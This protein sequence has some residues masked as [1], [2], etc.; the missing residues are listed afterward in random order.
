MRSID[1]QVAALRAKLAE[2]E[3][4]AARERSARRAVDEALQE[5]VRARDG[6]LDEVRGIAVRANRVGTQPGDVATELT[7]L[8][9][10]YSP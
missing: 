7:Q 2:A 1:V 4:D 6:L 3:Q 10:R 9:S 8:A 5:A